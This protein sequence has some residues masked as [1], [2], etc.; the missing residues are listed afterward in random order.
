MAKKKD[1]SGPRQLFMFLSFLMTF[2]NGITFL[3][4]I[5]WLVNGVPFDPIVGSLFI[6]IFLGY[7]IGLVGIFK[8]LPPLHYGILIA[9]GIN[10]VVSGILLFGGNGVGLLQGIGS[11][12]LLYLG[13][14][15]PIYFGDGEIAYNTERW[16][17]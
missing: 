6:I 10:L 11:F 12:L 3:G 14:R 8:P 17:R 2:A 9:S 4:I 15:F 1:E 13:L 16:L 5:S 7:F